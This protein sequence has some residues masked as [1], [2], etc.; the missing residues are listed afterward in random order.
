MGDVLFNIGFSRG[1]GGYDGYDGGGLWDN[2]WAEVSSRAQDQGEKVRPRYPF[3]RSRWLMVWQAKRAFLS[4]LARADTSNGPATEE[5]VQF[6]LVQKVLHE[7]RNFVK[8]HGCVCVALSSSSHS[9]TA[10]VTQRNAA[11]VD[12]RGTRPDQ[13]EPEI[14]TRCHLSDRVRVLKDCIAHEVLLRPGDE[15]SSG[16]VPEGSSASRS[17]TQFYFRER[18]L[19]HPCTRLGG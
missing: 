16:Q 6:H 14:G 7:F 2:S 15:G 17:N 5:V 12:A 19:R 18:Q 13:E 3:S 9:G 1:Y 11:S 10:N 8:D 4:F